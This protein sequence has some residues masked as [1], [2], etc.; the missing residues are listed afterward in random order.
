[1][2]RPWLLP[3]TAVLVSVLVLGCGEQQQP[4]APGDTDLS[5][6]PTVQH[7]ISR[8]PFDF[9]FFS[10]CTGDV[11]TFSATL[12][13]TVTIV[14]APDNDNHIEVVYVLRGTAT[15]EPSGTTYILKDTQLHNFNT[16]SGPAPNGTITD[17][18]V[19][20]LVSQGSLPNELFA[21]DTHLVFTG[22]GQFKVVVDN[23][24]SA[25]R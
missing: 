1:M 8:D 17:K 5:Q 2:S 15:G 10:A 16:P 9:S 7:F 12:F 23:V 11:I 13:T 20:V 6:A 24:R 3:T 4:T 25:C 21:F 14:S 19:S 18:E 22:T